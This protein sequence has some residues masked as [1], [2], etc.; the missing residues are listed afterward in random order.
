MTIKGLICK[1]LGQIQAKNVTYEKLMMLS[2]TLEDESNLFNYPVGMDFYFFC[3]YELKP[4]NPMM[5][6]KNCLIYST[7]ALHY[8]R[9][10]LFILDLFCFHITGTLTSDESK[11]KS[12]FFWL[13]PTHMYSMEKEDFTLI[14]Q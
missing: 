13:V 8:Q 3:L 10:S 9:F 2:H 14:L 4:T 11:K 6:M 5:L 7:A 1:N 12:N